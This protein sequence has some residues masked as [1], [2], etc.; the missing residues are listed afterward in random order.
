MTP[1]PL[2]TPLRV[3]YRREL[4]SIERRLTVDAPD[5]SARLA[6]FNELSGDEPPAGAERVPP[7]WPRPRMVYLAVLLVIAVIVTLCVY[8]AGRGR[9][10]AHSCQA[11]T[12]AH[13]GARGLACNAY[14]NTKQ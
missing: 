8:P 14:A 5:L 3:T 13:A 4:A 6:M 11:A 7:A 9:P 10:P 12:S 1:H 2:F